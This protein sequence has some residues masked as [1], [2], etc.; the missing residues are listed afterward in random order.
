MKKKTKAVELSEIDSNADEESGS[1][2]GDGK[3]SK[4]GPG[5]HPGPGPGPFSGVESGHNPKSDKL[6]DDKKYK[7]IDVKKR[8]VCTDIRKG[9]YT[10]SFISPSKSAKGK[11]VFNLAGDKVTL[12]YQL[13]QRISY[14]VCL[15]LV[16][17]E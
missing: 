11:L 14:R 3:G 12:N 4:P 1:G 10:L 5:P 2:P 9:K 6:G 7:G 8:L 16:L 15:E 17:K 13:I